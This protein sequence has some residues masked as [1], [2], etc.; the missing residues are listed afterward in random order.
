EHVVGVR[1]QRRVRTGA[2]EDAD[3]EA[4]AGGA[5]HVEVV[6]TVADDGNGPGRQAK[7]L[8]ESLDH[9]RPGLRP[10]AA[11]ETAG[12]VHEIVDAELRQLLMQGGF[13]VVRGDAER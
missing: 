9:T 1:C 6:Q 7:R 5:R 13:A 2:G 12:K 8:R 10:V 3:G 11:V 4:G